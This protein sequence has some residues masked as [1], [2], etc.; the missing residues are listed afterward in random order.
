MRGEQIIK[1]L[2]AV[3]LLARQRGTTIQEIGRELEISRRSVYRLIHTLENLGFPIEEPEYFGQEKRYRLMDNFTLK[4]PN[5]V[6]PPLYLTEEE[7]LLMLYLLGK[8]RPLADTEFAS[9]LESLKEKVFG[10]QDLRVDR[11]FLP[12]KEGDQK[13]HRDKHSHRSPVFIST[14]KH[15]KAYQGKESLIQNI[16]KAIQERRKCRIE[17]HAF[18]SGQVRTLLVDPLRIVEHRGGLYALVFY[19]KY[20]SY[21]TLAID[22]IFQL[23]AL[24]IHF[25]E[26]EGFDPEAL[27][28]QP[29][30]LRMN[31]PLRV[32]LWVSASQAYYIKDRKWGEEQR[33]EEREDGSIILSFSTSGSWDV[34]TWVLSLGS[35]AQLLEPLE[36]RQEIQEE[37]ERMRQAYNN[38]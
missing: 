31:D 7:T 32:R 18:S 27:L 11:A 1:I 36:L 21:L 30:S 29:F 28:S 5:L 6:L 17:Y 3:R 2:L 10:F 24:D 38:R 16:V 37:V 25:V 12:A 15:A 9:A 8:A 26:P 23:N 33:I 35:N 13:E 19:P 20:K 4:L 14:I 22:R 34:K